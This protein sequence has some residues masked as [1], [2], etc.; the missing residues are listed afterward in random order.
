MAHAMKPG[1]VNPFELEPPGC[2]TQQQAEWEKSEVRRL[3]NR[4]PMCGA[5]GRFL[6]KDSLWAHRIC[7]E[8][9]EYEHTGECGVHGRVDVVWP[10]P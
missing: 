5:C 4:R 9:P 3:A 2:T 7:W 1:L 8:Y 6:P 10:E